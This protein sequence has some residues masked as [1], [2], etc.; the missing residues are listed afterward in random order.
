MNQNA[1]SPRVQWATEDRLMEA[2]DLM[3]AAIGLDPRY[4]SHGEIQTGLSLDGRTWAP[5]FVDKMR[6]DFS[7]LGP[8]RRLAVALV[9]DELV[10]AGVA[11]FKQDDRARYVV[12]EDIA[13]SLTARSGGIG[14]ELIDFIETEA[15]RLGFQWAFLESGLDNHRAHA[16]FERNDYRPVSTVFCKP[17]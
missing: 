16:L 14:G 1:G 10:G 13:V 5:D 12:L 7:D 17:L 8:D 4:I 2:A 9:D 11:L 3:S 15:R 6:E